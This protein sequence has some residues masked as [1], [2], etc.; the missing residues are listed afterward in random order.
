NRYAR[1]NGLAIQGLCHLFA[2]TGDDAILTETVQAAEW[3]LAH[4][5]LAGGGFAHGE[6]REPGGPF[7]ADT[8]AMGNAQLRLYEVTGERRWLQGAQKA[9]AFLAARFVL[10]AGQ[11]LRAAAGD[12]VLPAA[13]DRDENT[14]VARFANLLW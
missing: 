7:L 13:V 10:P 1:E 12:S 9:A 4:R 11:G 3:I 14:A 2:V 6:G 5:A 8:L